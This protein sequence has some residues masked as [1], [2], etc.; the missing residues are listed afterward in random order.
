MTKFEHVT[1]DAAVKTYKS[2]NGVFEAL[3]GEVRELSK[4]SRMQHSARVRSL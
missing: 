3:L 4:K 2:A 1:T